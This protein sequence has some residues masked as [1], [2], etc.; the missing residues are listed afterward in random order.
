MREDLALRYIE[1]LLEEQPLLPEGYRSR[2]YVY[3]YH[4]P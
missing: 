4:T 3:S 1:V 2:V